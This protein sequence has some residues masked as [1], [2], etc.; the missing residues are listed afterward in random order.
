MSHDPDDPSR[1]ALDATHWVFDLDGTLTVAQHDFAALK[2]D[3][4]L[5]PHKA[6]LESIRLR[7]PAER[8]ALLDSVHR[9]EVVLADRAVAAPDALALVQALAGRWAT[10]GVL[11]RNTRE[12]A[13]RTLRGAGLSRFF[14][15]AHVL[16]R[17]CAAPKPA[18]DGIQMLLARW[19]ARPEQAVMVGDNRFDIQAGKAAGVHTVWVNRVGAPPLQDPAHTTVTALDILR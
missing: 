18:P 9:W 7:P 19:G 3:L 1:S 17:T 4:G 5:D 16:G 15:D 10:L 8:A 11:T 14:P 13:L 12:T 2:H 6:V